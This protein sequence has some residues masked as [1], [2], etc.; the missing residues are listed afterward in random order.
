MVPTVTIMDR[1]RIQLDR[2]LIATNVS[3]ALR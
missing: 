3:G 1:Q 2:V